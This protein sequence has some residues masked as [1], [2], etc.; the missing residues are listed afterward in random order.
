MRAD[1]GF[2]VVQSDSKAFYIMHVSGW[3]SVKFLKN[4]FLILGAYSNAVVTDFNNKTFVF[5]SCT[6]LNLWS[7][8]AVLDRV[9]YEIIQHVCQMQFISLDI[10]L[11]CFQIAVDGTFLFLQR[12][13]R[14]F[15]GF[16]DYLMYIY[17][18]F[19]QTDILFLQTRHLQY[20][21][22]LLL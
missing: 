21:F 1:N 9:V 16:L 11:F 15:D 3:H 22:N 10:E 6:D 2:H 13:R 14:V 5:A 17:Q 12:S 19:L 7:V 4:I 20:T 18:F 8:C